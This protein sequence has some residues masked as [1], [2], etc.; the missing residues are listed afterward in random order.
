MFRLF[1]EIK[2]RNTAIS[3]KKKTIVHH[4]PKHATTTNTTHT[5]THPTKHYTTSTWKRSQKLPP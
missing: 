4:K 3:F 1:F 5:T 2:G